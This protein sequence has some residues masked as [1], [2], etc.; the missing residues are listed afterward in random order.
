MRDELHDVRL[1]KL[2]E[3]YEEAYERFVLHMADHVVRDP[4]LRTRLRALAA[5][6]D[7]HHDRIAEHLRRLNARLG[8]EDQAA[9][10]RAALLDVVEVEE[11][12]RRFYL[13][14]VDEAHDPEVAR[15]F[16]ELAGEEAEHARLAREALAALERRDGGAA[17]RW[18]RRLRLAGDGGEEEDLPLREGVSDFGARLVPP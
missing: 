6:G 5:P 9:V 15:L 8:P 1:L 2:A 12:A 14:H 17:P 16:R 13:E 18:A 7:R 10:E 11:A 3:M 4:D